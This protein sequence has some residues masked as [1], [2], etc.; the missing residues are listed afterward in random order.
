MSLK[1]SDIDST[2]NTRPS[3]KNEAKLQSSMM[4][5]S[6]ITSFLSHHGSML[7]T[8]EQAHIEEK[9]V[10]DVRMAHD[11][12]MLLYQDL[13]LLLEKVR[14]AEESIRNEGTKFFEARSLQRMQHEEMQQRY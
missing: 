1:G 10:W 12:L 2:S 11:A 7:N 3:S 6:H 13:E 5:S 4:S 8:G 9:K 14:S